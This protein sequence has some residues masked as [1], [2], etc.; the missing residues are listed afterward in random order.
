MLY[1]IN[2]FPLLLDETNPTLLETE[3]DIERDFLL[4]K[5]FFSD[6]ATITE[7]NVRCDH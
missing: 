2:I 3:T 5:S 7:F 6:I 1:G 4:D